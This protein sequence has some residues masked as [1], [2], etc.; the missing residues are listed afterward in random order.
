MNQH[1]GRDMHRSDSVQGAGLR[2]RQVDTVL[3]RLHTLDLSEDGDSSLQKDKIREPEP[4]LRSEAENETT[5]LSL[6]G[7]IRNLELVRH[8]LAGAALAANVGTGAGG[9]GVG[10][11]HGAAAPQVGTQI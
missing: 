1:H 3:K 2:S 7:R 10:N 5:P 8:F 6:Q 11:W 9:Q 4:H